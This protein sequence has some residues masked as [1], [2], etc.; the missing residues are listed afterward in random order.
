MAK[1]TLYKQTNPE[2]KDVKMGKSNCSLGRF[3]CTTCSICMISSKFGAHL[4]PPV[5]AGKYV[6]TIDGLLDW[7][8]SDFSPLK[9]VARVRGY[10]EKRLKEWLK[11]S[12]NTAIINVKN[13]W[14]PFH[15]VAADRFSIIGLNGFDPIDGMPLRLKRKYEILGFAL[16]S[17]RDN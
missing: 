9:F 11:D 12:N 10:D 7:S 14:I 17:R 15:W 1:Y 13:R 16:F 2:W 5:A 4:P 8:A 6:Y 3:G